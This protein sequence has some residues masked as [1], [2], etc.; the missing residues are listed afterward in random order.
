VSFQ[1]GLAAEFLGDDCNVKMAPAVFRA[2][3][4]SV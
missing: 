4:A 1:A 3:M 2:F